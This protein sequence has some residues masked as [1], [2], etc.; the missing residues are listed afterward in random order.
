MGDGA[1]LAALVLHAIIN[2]S[3]KY[4]SNYPAHGYSDMAAFWMELIL[5]T[6]LVSVILGTASGAQQ[7]GS[8]AAIGLLAAERWR[9]RTGEGQ[10]I[11][12]SLSDVAFAMVGHQNR[13]SLVPQIA[14][15]L[16][17]FVDRHRVDARERLVQ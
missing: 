9:T 15:N 12:L 1:A 2:V 16:L 6:G 7:I 17:N 13:D 10:Q 4:G 5:T 8:L 3:A 11:R 14:D